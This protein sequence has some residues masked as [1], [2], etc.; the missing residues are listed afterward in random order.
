[1]NLDLFDRIIYINLE[2]RLDRRAQTENLLHSLVTDKTRIER[3]VALEHENGS[4]GCAMSHVEVL[5]RIRS[6]GY[7]RALVVEDDI[8]VRSQVDPS[9]LERAHSIEHDVLMLSGNVLQKKT[10][11]HGIIRVIEAQT[12][13]AYSPSPDYID[14]LISNFEESIVLLSSGVHPDKAAIDQNWKK[15][16]SEHRWL[17]IDGMPFSQRSGYSDIEKKDV[18][19]RC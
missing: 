19:Y 8:E 2:R 11:D 3:F 6:K 13:A 17:G 14:T 5:K 9:T 4:I 18:D 15:L 7:T 1:M 16:Q 10:I 12:T